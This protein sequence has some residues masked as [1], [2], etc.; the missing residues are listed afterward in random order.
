M[1]SS[2]FAERTWETLI[3][4]ATTAAIGIGVVNLA[5]HL[6]SAQ[7]VVETQQADNLLPGFTNDYE[8]LRF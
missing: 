8:P 1:I 7:V 2:D 3:V 5:T 4:L 6:N